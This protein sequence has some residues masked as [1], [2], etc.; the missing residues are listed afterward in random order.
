MQNLEQLKAALAQGVVQVTFTKTD[1]STRVMLA[2]WKTSL[3]PVMTVEESHTATATK[4]ENL[5]KVYDIQAQG[6]RSFR[7]ERV[8][9]WSTDIT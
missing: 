9:S 3:L 7:A 1:G 6:W 5:V 4:D 8:Q 2:T